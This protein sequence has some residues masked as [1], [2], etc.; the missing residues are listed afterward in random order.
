MFRFAQHDKKGGARGFVRDSKERGEMRFT[1]AKAGVSSVL[2]GFSDVGQVE[3][4]ARY[5]EREALDQERV[6][7]VMSVVAGHG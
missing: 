1:L 2:I 3:A 7:R 6:L 5:A 4:A